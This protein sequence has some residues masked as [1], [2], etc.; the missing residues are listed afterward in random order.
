VHVDSRHC[1]SSKGLSIMNSNAARAEIG[2]VGGSGLYELDGLQ[3]AEW[4][5]VPTPYGETSD[6]LLVGT[7]AGRGVAFLPRH[8][9]GHLLTPSEI[10]V[11]ANVYALKSLGVRSVL[12]VSAVGSLRE[13]LAPGDLVVCDQIVDRTRG[14]RPSTFFGGGLVVHVAFDEP[15]CSRLRALLADVAPRVSGAEVHTSG[16]YCCMEGPQFSTRAESELYRSWGMDVIG[17]TALPEAKLAR[18][19]E[20]CYAGLALVTDYDCWHPD[21]GTVTAELV[22][23]VMGRNAQAAKAVVSAF[24]GSP[25]VDADCAC[26]SALAH[27]IITDRR[28]VPPAA[29]DDLLV[30]SYFED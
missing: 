2:I 22:A 9:R 3:D 8:G 25:D 7:L 21:H 27:A 20:L 1:T 11:R 30:G 14:V 16:T 6:A 18:E 23:E 4:V 12:S 17:M 10:P 5:R 13:H 28:A 24:V 29:R 26:H 19:A 15:Y